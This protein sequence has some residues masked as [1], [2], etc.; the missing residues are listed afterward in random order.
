MIT[1]HVDE[2][3]AFD[4]LSIAKIKADELGLPQA[5]YLDLREEIGAHVGLNKTLDALFSDEYG[6][7]CQCNR[8]V[9]TL[10]DMAATDAV[11]ASVVKA[12]NDRRFAAKAALQAKFWPE[13]PLKEVKG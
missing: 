4:R 7:L 2:A 10:V 5:T 12:A 11:K 9:W 8:E 6:N 1:I 3:E 13:S